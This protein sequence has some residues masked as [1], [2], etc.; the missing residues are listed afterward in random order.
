MLDDGSVIE[1]WQKGG[2]RHI[3]D[4]FTGHSEGTVIDVFEV[5]DN[6]DAAKAEAFLVKQIGQKYDYSSV[7]R[8]VTRRKALDNR[9]KFCSELAELSLIAGGLRLLNGSPSEHS[10]RDT[11]LSPYLRYK[12]TIK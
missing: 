7:M 2:V 4:P 5:H 3:P 9:K 10:P 8:F 1:A 12:E 6:F 11:L